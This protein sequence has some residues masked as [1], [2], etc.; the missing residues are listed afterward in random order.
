MKFKA[1]HLEMEL[2]AA[3]PDVR[4]AVVGLDE[5]CR[6]GALPEV[7]VTQV[8]RSADE[9]ED[10]YFRYAESL[11]AKLRAGAPLS[12]E[13]N[14]LARE[15]ESMSEAQRRQWARF[16]FSWHR[17]GCAV[18]IR[19]RHYSRTQL[20]G[21]MAWLRHGRT[22]GPWELLSHD[23]S[24]GDHVH[25]GRRDFEFRTKHEQSMKDAKEAENV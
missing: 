10:I 14:Q 6:E 2:H 15:L 3:H 4:A 22:V 1:P 25:I 11:L 23:V 16:R 20:A 18:D 13:D 24:S 17:V 19:N 7:V 8:L 9:Q 5:W 12:S 21:V